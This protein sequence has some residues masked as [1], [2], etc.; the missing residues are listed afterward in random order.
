MKFVILPLL[1]A[2]AGCA[3]KP[4]PHIV[5]EPPFPTPA[6]EPVT[7]VRHPEVVRAYHL[8]R[9][10]DSRQPDL[11]HEGHP[12][13]RVEAH[14]SWN[15]KPGLPTAIEVSPL[16]PPPSVAYAPPPTNDVV[17]AELKRQKDATERVMWEAHQL[18]KSYDELQKV[19]HDVRAVAKDH[20][21]L[22]GL[23][24]HSDRRVTQMQE[25]MKKLTAGP[26]AA[27]PEPPVNEPNPTPARE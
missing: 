18:A 14:S 2:I 9:R 20:V 13:Y 8:G 11:M 16:N 7:S 5:F 6:I 22:K 19:L 21:T 25:E 27:T 1:I 4:Q 17:L 15:L 12:I 26:P 3:S 10:V 23:I 24:L